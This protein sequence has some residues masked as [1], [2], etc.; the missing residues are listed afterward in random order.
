MDRDYSAYHDDERDDLE[1]AMI[2]NSL[3]TKLSRFDAVA[4]LVCVQV[5]SGVFSSSSQVD[6]H[7]PTPAVSLAI[8][9]FAGLV[10]WSGAA[11]FTELGTM[12][13]VNGGMQEYLHEIYGPFMSFLASWIWVLG[14]K[15][16]T[17]AMLSIMFAQY[18]TITMFSRERSSMFINQ[19]LAILTLSGVILFNAIG[20]GATLKFSR[21]FFY[22]KLSTV[23]VL[24]ICSIFVVLFGLHLG[25]G[26]TSS[27]WKTNNWFTIKNY[28]TPMPRFD[29]KNAEIWGTLDEMSVAL[30]AGLW[31]YSGWDNVSA[32]P[33]QPKLLYLDSLLT[34][35][36]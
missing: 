34:N 23:F 13:P 12:M 35:F 18:W 30:Y 26:I 20:M 16:A 10:A 24:A 36:S 4:L 7:S 28:V 6:S 5:G 22:S 17:M 8:W 9:L 15:P 14:I 31:A 29:W 33:C 19:F 25:P 21:M 32:I 11:S 27:D 2:E 3:H 1:L